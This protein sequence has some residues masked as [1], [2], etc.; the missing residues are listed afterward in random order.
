MNKPIELRFIPKWLGGAIAHYK[1]DVKDFD[2]IVSRHDVDLYNVANN[3]LRSAFSRLQI[4]DFNMPDAQIAKAFSD[5]DAMFALFGQNPERKTLQQFALTH[6]D[7]VPDKYDGIL[8]LERDGGRQ[9]DLVTELVKA[10]AMYRGK[11][12]AYA[13]SS[14]KTYLGLVNKNDIIGKSHAVIL[15]QQ[16]ENDED[17]A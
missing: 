3:L 2:S 6:F 1:A 5:D 15:Q 4:T 17:A 12:V 11:D 7:I 8:I 14:F 13:S 10:L 16:L 9:K